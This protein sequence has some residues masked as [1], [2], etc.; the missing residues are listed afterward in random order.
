MV[1]SEMRIKPRSLL[2][3]D[4]HIRVEADTLTCLSSLFI[5]T[6]RTMETEYIGHICNIS[7]FV[8]NTLLWLPLQCD[9]AVTMSWR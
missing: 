9:Q 4:S 2:Q 3:L 1:S 5:M 7:C 8:A 6:S